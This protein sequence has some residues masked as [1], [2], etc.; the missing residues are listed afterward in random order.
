MAAATKARKE[1]KVQRPTISVDVARD[2]L[3]RLVNRAA[4]GER[5]VIARHGLRAAALVSIADLEK[6][7]GSAA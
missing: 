5:I 2:T 1:M 4:E 6:L 7:E 3:G